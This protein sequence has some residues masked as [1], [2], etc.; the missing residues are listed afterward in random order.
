[1]KTFQTAIANPLRFL[2]LPLFLLALLIN[3]SIGEPH[4]T[5]PIGDTEGLPIRK[6]AATTGEIGGSQ[7]VPRSFSDIGGGGNETRKVTSPLAYSEIG[8]NGGGQPRTFTKTASLADIEFPIGGHGGTE[9][10]RLLDIGG[11][12]GSTAPRN[13][14]QT[15]SFETASI[16][17][18]IG[19]QGVSRQLKEIGGNQTAPRSNANIGGIGVGQVP[20]RAYI[21]AASLITASKDLS[22]GGQGTPRHL[23]E[24]GG[25][26][27]PRHFVE[28]GDTNGTER[29]NIVIGG[30]QT[31]PRSLTEIGGTQGAPRPYSEIGGGQLPPREIGGPQETRKLVGIGGQQTAPR[32]IGIEIGG[33]SCPRC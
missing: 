17:L 4:Q 14:L 10:R 6:F 21:A 16:D 22:I 2:K 3:F 8:G 18:P 12:G 9:T 7:T 1:M 27:A 31:V 24:I 23:T 20:P 28:I 26:E 15:G 5:N 13:I 33:N 25:Q 29:R 30:S 11:N 19:N 32:G